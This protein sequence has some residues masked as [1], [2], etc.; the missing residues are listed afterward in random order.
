MATENKEWPRWLYRRGTGEPFL[1]PSQEHLN[2][3]KEKALWQEKPWIKSNEKKCEK[4]EKLE[5]MVILLEAEIKEKN[6][7][8]MNLK[9]KRGLEN[10]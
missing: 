2:T 9:I 8:I 10:G 5:E 1:C 7:Q 3:M 4:C 6:R